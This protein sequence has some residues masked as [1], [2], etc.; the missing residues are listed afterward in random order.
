MKIFFISLFF[1]IVAVV[2]IAG[3]RGAKSERTPIMVF[4][5]M[6]F[7]PKY[8]PQSPSTFFPDGM[9]DRKPLSGT[10]MRGNQLNRREVFSE[11]QDLALLQNP[12]WSRG[13][14]SNGN[15]IDYIPFEVD[16]ELMD[17]GR[18]KYDIFCKVCHGAAGRGNG[19]T[20]NYGINASNLVTELYR[21]RPDGNLYNTITNGYNTMYGYGD[22]LDVRERWAV[23]AYLRALQRAH[24]AG[25]ADLTPQQRQEL[26]L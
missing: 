15:E 22:K 5:D 7:Q 21:E 1:T 11:S 14:D 2:S 20:G 3:F 12:E 23:V 16:A 6:D 19:V 8:H 26:G 4:P 13:R 18:E 24:A 9:S 25:E 10:V 17:T